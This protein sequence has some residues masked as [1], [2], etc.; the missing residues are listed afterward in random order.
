MI[1]AD[2]NRRPQI[3]ISRK[4]RNGGQPVL[5]K[6]ISVQGLLVYFL[7]LYVCMYNYEVKIFTRSESRD[8]RISRAK[9]DILSR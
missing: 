1:L 7:T 9:H 8:S 2:E 4:P 6:V 3:A 5:R